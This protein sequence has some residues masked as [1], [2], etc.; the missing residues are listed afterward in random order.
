M[1]QLTAF[2]AILA[3]AWPS[4]AASPKCDGPDNWAAGMANATLKNAG[5]IVSDQV[6]FSKTKVKRLASEPI[7]KGLYRQV[8]RV[9]FTKYSGE[10]IEAITVNTASHDECSESGVE[11]FLIR[12]YFPAS[13]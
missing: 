9:T 13:D 5:V 8:H 4:L 12:Q 2:L 11:V 3:F 7:G 10:L 6:D 1:R